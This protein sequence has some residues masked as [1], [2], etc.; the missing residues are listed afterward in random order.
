MRKRRRRGSRFGGEREG[1]REEKR[2]EKTHCFF[3]NPQ[4]KNEK[5]NRTQS[6]AFSSALRSLGPTK[7]TPDV[8]TPRYEA[9]VAGGADE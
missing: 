6:D 2:G 1:A 5:K 9:V 3:F 8:R 7:P 4:K